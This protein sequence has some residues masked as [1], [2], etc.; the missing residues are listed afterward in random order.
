MMPIWVKG[1]Q[2]FMITTTAYDVGATVNPQINDA[3]IPNT[4]VNTNGTT[5]F[6]TP[7][8]QP[9]VVRGFNMYVGTNTSSVDVTLSLKHGKWNGGT[10]HPITTTILFTIPAGETGY[11]C[12]DPSVIAESDRTW[13]ARDEIQFEIKQPQPASGNCEK[14]TFGVCYEIT[15]EYMLDNNFPPNL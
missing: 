1:N 14:L 6:R 8:F 4:L 5:N 11:F 7:I 9:G 12:M 10:G 2:C 15:E 13:A 3:V